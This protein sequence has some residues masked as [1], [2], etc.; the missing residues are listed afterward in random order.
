[1]SVCSDKKAVEPPK[2]LADFGGRRKIF[3]RR[4]HISS[5]NGIER[6]FGTDRRSG[7]DRRSA[8]KSSPTSSEKRKNFPFATRHAK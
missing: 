1:M 4:I 3:E 8:A 5:T 7:F 2:V 6:R